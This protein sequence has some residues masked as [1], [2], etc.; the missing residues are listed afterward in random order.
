[1]Y[2]YHIYIYI[3]IYNTL[4]CLCLYMQYMPWNYT[5]SI[6]TPEGFRSELHVYIYAPP[7]CRDAW[8]LFIKIFCEIRRWIFFCCSPNYASGVNQKH[9]FVRSRSVVLQFYAVALKLVVISKT[10][11]GCSMNKS[12]Y[13]SKFRVKIIIFL[14]I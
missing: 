8:N 4:L 7:Q 12:A 5:V 1:M 2:I 14:Y 6:A 13:C 10:S 9:I 11:S 3:Y